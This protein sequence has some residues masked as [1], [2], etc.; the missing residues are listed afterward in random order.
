MLSGYSF[1]KKY[2]PI[3]LHF[4]TA[5]DI[6]RYDG[7]TKSVS[8]EHFE[9]RKDKNLFAKIGK[10][11]N[12]DKEA[13]QFCLSNFILTTNDNWIYE[14]TDHYE[15]FLKWKG[16][17][18]SFVQHLENEIYELCKHSEK[19]PLW[20]KFISRTPNGNLPPL[21]Q[22]Y[23]HRRI[24][25]DT[26]VVLNNLHTEFIDKWVSEC[27]TD[28]FIQKQLVYLKKYTPFIHTNSHKTLP[29]VQKLILETT[30]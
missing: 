4:T 12:N 6:F 14:D 3:H 9:N 7:R 25:A 13:G 8:P 23:L 2:A 1:F 20:S 27:S 10:K 28:P 24:S 18:Q 30:F 21:L 15:N 19:L 29:I 17:R 26:V 16:Y 22:L 5:Y 11:I